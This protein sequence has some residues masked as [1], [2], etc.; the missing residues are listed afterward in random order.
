[1]KT[2]GRHTKFLKSAFNPLLLLLFSF[3]KLRRY[4]NED[5]LLRLPR[6]LS[7]TYLDWFSIYDLKQKKSYGHIRIERN[8]NVPPNMAFILTYVSD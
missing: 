6:D 5:V 7:L 2:E 3:G 8:L 4:F 1:M